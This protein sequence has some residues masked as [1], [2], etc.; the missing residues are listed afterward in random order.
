M[1]QAVY[2]HT[3]P[4]TL[5]R[6]MV[7]GMVLASLAISAF[8]DA[9]L[10]GPVVAIVFIVVLLLFHSLTVQIDR[11]RLTLFFGLGVIRRSFPLGEIREAR[12][13]R[14]HWY[15]GWGIR[16][17]PHGWLYNVSGFDAV[18]IELR[19]GRKVRIGTDRP[20]ELQQAVLEAGR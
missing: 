14:N 11:Q 18:E 17:T 8:T 13:V 5:V 4:G 16:W 3:Q 6:W 9:G 15:Y 1:E 7:G 19:D 12:A 10:T 20:M 2:R